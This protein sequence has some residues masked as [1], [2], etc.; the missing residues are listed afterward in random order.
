MSSISEQCNILKVICLKSLALIQNCT[1]FEVSKII[2]PLPPEHL[3]VTD[4]SLPPYTPPA[5]RTRKA[6][7]RQCEA[8][9]LREDDE[10]SSLFFSPFAC[11]TP[12]SSSPQ[13]SP[14]STSLPT[15]PTEPLSVNMLPV[16]DHAVLS[17]TDTVNS[18]TNL[19]T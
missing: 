1:F 3:P 4:T 6:A 5:K 9:L 10:E 13:P 15:T 14:P 12:P 19:P 8:E 7:K 17:N 18:N 11:W 2:H 16:E